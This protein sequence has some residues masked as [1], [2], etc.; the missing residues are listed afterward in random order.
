M[1]AVVS[2]ASPHVKIPEWEQVLSAGAG[3]MS[4]VLAAHALRLR[5][6]LDHQMVHLRP[7]CLD[8]L[9]LAPHERIGGFIHIGRPPG[10]AEDRP[11]P[12][13][14]EIAPAIPLSCPET[15]WEIMFYDTRKN[16]HIVPRGRIKVNVVSDRSTSG[17][18]TPGRLRLCAFSDL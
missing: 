12:P 18:R 4:L 16:D 8:E 15:D 17:K 7:R 14:D 9:G 1:I 2:R 13:L 3:A 10:P 11:R 5:G 6:K